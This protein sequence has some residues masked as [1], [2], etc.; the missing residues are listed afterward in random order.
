MRPEPR[1][2]WTAACRQSLTTWGAAHCDAAIPKTDS[3]PA[4]A[5]AKKTHL[6]AVLPA[7]FRLV[8]ANKFVIFSLPFKNV[9]DMSQNF[10]QPLS[11]KYWNARLTRAWNSIHITHSWTCF[12]QTL[13]QFY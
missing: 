8:F 7:A 5:A 9:H 13:S 4:G 11:E 10:N 12:T 1:T 2:A 3:H 6:G